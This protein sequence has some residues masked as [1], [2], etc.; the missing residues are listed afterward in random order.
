MRTRLCAQTVDGGEGHG[1]RAGFAA[2][3][4]GRTKEDKTEDAAQDGLPET[5]GAKDPQ[6]A[7][8]AREVDHDVKN[9]GVTSLDEQLM[10]LV[11][12][13]VEQAEKAD[14]QED[15][16]LFPAAGHGQ[17]PVKQAGQYEIF[18]DVRDLSQ[19]QVPGKPGMKV[20]DRGK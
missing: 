18:R 9:R 19:E 6:E 13:G 1:P 20:R 11:G 16:A 14:D 4:R 17:C 15:P 12:R 3:G 10:R 5:G 8:N 2:A 7:K